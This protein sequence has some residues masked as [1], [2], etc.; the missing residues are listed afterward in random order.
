M[1]FKV[2]ELP[3][4]FN[5]I[6]TAIEESQDLRTMKVVELIGTLQTFEITLNDRLEKKHKNMAFV[7]EENLNE[8]IYQK[9]WPSL[10]RSSTNR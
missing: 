2:D 4:R 3:K 10:A 8:D 1:R 6:V 9:P 7:S 5:I